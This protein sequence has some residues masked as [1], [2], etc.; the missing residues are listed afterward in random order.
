MAWVYPWIH[1]LAAR[2]HK[3]KNSIKLFK[4]HPYWFVLWFFNCWF[5]YSIIYLLFGCCFF[6]LCFCVLNDQTKLI[7]FTWRS[8][9]KIRHKFEY[10]F[11]DQYS[12]PLR[13]MFLT[14]LTVL[15][16]QIVACDVLKNGVFV[17]LSP[18]VRLKSLSPCRHL[19]YH[20][21]RDPCA[22]CD[23]HNTTCKT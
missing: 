3:Q 11:R 13:S 6:S 20:G 9:R 10:F 8:D 4:K 5:I 18:G 22:H 14:Y 7:T 16:S 21:D 19:R 2:K 1:V 23:Q 17:R 15:S 12:L